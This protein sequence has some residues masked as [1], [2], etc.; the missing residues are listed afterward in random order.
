M[1]CDFRDVTFSLPPKKDV[2]IKSLSLRVLSVSVACIV[3]LFSALKLEI[4]NQT[5]REK[6][7]GRSPSCLGNH[8]V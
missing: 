3:S 4:K 5:K 8:C 6:V 1:T 2:A 7:L